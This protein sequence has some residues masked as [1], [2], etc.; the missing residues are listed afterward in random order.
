MLALTADTYREFGRFSWPLVIKGFLARPAFRV[1][2]TMRWCQAAATC[3]PALRWLV[4]GPARVLHRIS[5]QRAGIEMS[6]RTEVAPG[7]AITHG[8]GIVVSPCARFGSNVTLLHGA[9]VGQADS[10]G[11]NGERK[12][13]FPVIED[14]VWIG[15]HAIVVGGITVGRGS[16]IAGGAYVNE[17]VPPYSV[18]MGNPSQVVK[19]GCTPDV[20][21]RFTEEMLEPP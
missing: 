5:A 1:V 17:D 12:H 13:S 15:P 2:I 6:W 3:S 11:P 4:L 14:E 20:Q 18:V 7:F 10:I 8:R 16:R 9:T 19:T 21:N